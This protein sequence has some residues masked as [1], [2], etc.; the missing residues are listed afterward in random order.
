MIFQN[1]VQAGRMLATRL[2]HLLGQDVVVLG[3]PRGGVPVAYEVAKKLHVPLDVIVVRKLGLPSQPEL[4]LGAVGEGGVVVI[5]EEVARMTRMNRADFAQI[6]ARERKEVERR[7]KSF[8]GDRLGV[9]LEGRIAL[10]IDDGIATGS[11]AQ[12]ACKV[13]RASG[14]RRVILAVPVGAADSLRTLQADADEVVCLYIPERLY[15]VGEWYEDFSAT[16]DDEVV[17]LLRDASLNIATA[18]GNTR[19]VAVVQSPARDEEIKVQAGAVVLAGHLIVPEEVNGIIIFAHGSGSSRHSPRNQEV[20]RELNLAGLATLLFDLLTPAEEADRSNVFD[21]ELLAGRLVEATR[22]LHNQS[23]LT[24]LPVGYFGASTGA[25][26][27]LWAAADSDVDISAVVSRGGRA[28]LAG[29]KLSKV[30]AATLLI[31]GE[32][33]GV[34]I[35]LNRAAQAKLRCENKLVI[36]PR[37]SHLFEEPGALDRVA[38]LASKWFLT[39]QALPVS[40]FSR[41][42]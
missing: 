14:A 13:A 19:N 38:E 10:V 15:S 32:R 2:M 22:W 40:R 34:V 25:A 6:E 31:V 29:S 11:T 7:A 16:C 28:D 17:E 12:A 27:A 30:R 36:V 39:H 5:N 20:A 37:A 9:S 23:G 24:H 26:A 4:A 1:R 35:E 41:V 18:S 42:P 3:L 21:I 33:D 8:R